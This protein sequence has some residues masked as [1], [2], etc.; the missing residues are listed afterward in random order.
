MS[1]LSRKCGSLDVSQTYGPPRIA[2]LVLSLYKYTFIYLWPYNPCG[3]WPFF[4]FLVY[5]QSV[6]LLGRGISPSQDRYLHA[7]QHKQNKCTQIS[8]PRVGFETT[9]AVFDQAKRVHALDRAGTVIGINT[10]TLHS[11]E[12]N[13]VTSV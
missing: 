6:E 1:R 4:S 8:K 2:L 11:Y 12:G 13:C 5:T 3:P 7:G 10:H 9:I